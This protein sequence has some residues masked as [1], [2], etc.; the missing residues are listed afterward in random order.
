MTSLEAWNKVLSELQS[1]IDQTKEN[2]V[3][4]ADFVSDNGEI[5]CLG[6]QVAINTINKYLKEV[7]S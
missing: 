4:H 1:T 2:S 7:E 5:F 3:Y 6:I